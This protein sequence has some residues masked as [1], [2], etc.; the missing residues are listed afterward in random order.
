M[1]KKWLLNTTSI[2]LPPLPAHEWNRL[3]DITLGAISVGFPPRRKQLGLDTESNDNFNSLI[4]HFITSAR[5]NTS[6]ALEPKEDGT[7]CVKKQETKDGPRVEYKRSMRRI[8]GSIWNLSPLMTQNPD[9]KQWNITWGEQ[10]SR[11]ASGHLT[12]PSAGDMELFEP[13]EG[14]NVLNAGPTNRLKNKARGRRNR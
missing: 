3:R 12:E 4:R 10:K 14:S 2:V 1:G 6:T 8:Y 7:L 5:A 9:T 11:A 13:E